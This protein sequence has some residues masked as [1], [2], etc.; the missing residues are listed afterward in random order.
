MKED[1]MHTIVNKHPIIS[2]FVDKKLIKKDYVSLFNH[3]QK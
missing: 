2:E 1:R 3:F